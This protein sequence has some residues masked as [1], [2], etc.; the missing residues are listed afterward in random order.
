[1]QAE[2]ERAIE[3]MTQDVALGDVDADIDATWLREIIAGHYAVWSFVEWG[4]F[5]ALFP[6]S[7]EALSDT[8]AASMLFETFDRA[9]H[10]QD[11][12]HYLLMLEEQ[13]PGFDARPAK[14]IWLESPRYQPLRKMVE[15]LAFL[16]RDWGESIVAVNLVFDPIVTEVVISSL[17]GYLAPFH[18]DVVSRAIIASAERDRSRSLAW[19]REFVGMVT[20]PGVPAASDNRDLIAGWV[21]HWRNQALRVVEPFEE[22]YKTV[23]FLKRQFSEVLADAVSEQQRLIGELGISAVRR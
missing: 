23:P 13:V 20:A 6:A 3:R 15:E 8:V 7:R 1:M 5:R 21:T 2:Q 18:G 19:T 16:V 10:S 9:R 14:D 22:L 4:L 11:I 17:V 12:V